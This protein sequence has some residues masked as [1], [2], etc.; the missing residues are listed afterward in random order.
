MVD[1]RLQ[2][3]AILQYQLNAYLE[4]EA[5]AHSVEAAKKSAVATVGPSLT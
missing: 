1:E 4:L 5:Q 3:A 2:T